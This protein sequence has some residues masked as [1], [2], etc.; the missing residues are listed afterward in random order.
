VTDETQRR[1]KGASLLSS[2]V[3]FSSKGIFK[4]MGIFFR[5]KY[6][7]HLVVTLKFVLVISLK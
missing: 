5:I 7:N 1:A 3:N 2:L 4:H 6:I